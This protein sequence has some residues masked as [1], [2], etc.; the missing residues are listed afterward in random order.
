MNFGVF[1]TVSLLH[2]MAIGVGRGGEG[3]GIQSHILGT[4]QKKLIALILCVQIF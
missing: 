3:R 2:T 4:L 1:A